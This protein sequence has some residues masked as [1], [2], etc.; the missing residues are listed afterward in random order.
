MGDKSRATFFVAL[1]PSSSSPAPNPMPFPPPSYYKNGMNE[2]TNSACAVSCTLTSPA[3]WPST[4][5]SLTLLSPCHSWIWAALPL[6][7]L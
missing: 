6:L 5:Q 2:L 1:S 4:R 3:A 7:A